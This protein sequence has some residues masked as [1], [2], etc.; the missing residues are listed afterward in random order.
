M[1]VTGLTLYDWIR[2]HFPRH[3]TKS[4]IKKENKLDFIKIKTFCASKDTIKK[5]KR[6]P[7]EWEKI[8]ANRISDKG[9]TSGE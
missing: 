8:L 9:L 1:K 7:T 4:T 2:Q 3:D 5:V 6:Q